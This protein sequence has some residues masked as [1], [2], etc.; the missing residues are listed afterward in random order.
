[1]NEFILSLIKYTAMFV[2]MVYAYMKL[3]RIK[4]TIVDLFTMP[5]FIILAAILSGVKG[6]AQIFVPIGFLIFGIIFLLLRFKKPIYET[7]TVGTISLGMSIIAYFIVF[8]FGTPVT[9]NFNFAINE[10]VKRI[11]AAVFIAICQIVL[12]IIFFSIKRFQS[13]LIPKNKNATFDIILYLSV[14]CIFAMTLLYADNVKEYMLKVVMLVIILCGLLLVFWCRKHITY[15]YLES[16]ARQR[17]EILENEL[18]E[19]KLNY[20]EI[21]YQLNVYAKQ[22]HYLNKALPDCVDLINH[23]AAETNCDYVRSAQKIMNSALCAMNIANEKCSLQNIPQT[24]VKLIDAPIKRLYNESDKKNLDASV[25]ISANVQSWISDFRLDANDMYTLMTYLC[26]NAII[27]AYDSPNAKVRI[28]LCETAEQK[29]LIRIYDSGKLF[30]ESVLAK[31]GKEKITTHSDGHGIGLV[32]VFKIIKNY[33]ASFTLDET[34]SK[35][36]FTK[37]IEIAFDGQGSIT[38]RTNRDSI[39][40][41]C[42]DRSDIIIERIDE[43]A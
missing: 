13:G 12:I 1:M 41:A 5:L 34:T 27:S 33:G 21:E 29:P 23:A 17:L 7:V 8:V 26:D 25:D 42:A 38:V 16:N 36:G 2:C 43:A 31:L 37:C 9:L 28:E 39:S 15:N 20:E 19:R 32:S 35:L 22:F 40:H 10:E 18:K 4:P 14:A 11:S 6:N 30:D 3:Q 24:G